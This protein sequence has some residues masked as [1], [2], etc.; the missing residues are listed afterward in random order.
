M[1]GV[2][3]VLTVWIVGL[4][5]FRPS[6]LLGRDDDQMSRGV[7]ILSREERHACKTVERARRSCWEKLAPGAHLADVDRLSPI[8][9]G[10]AWL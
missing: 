7:A 5:L 8:W 9:E 10:R 2:R 4:A 6:T 1:H 3:K